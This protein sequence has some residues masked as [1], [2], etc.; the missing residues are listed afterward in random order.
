M[1]TM[2]LS[3]PSSYGLWDGEKLLAECAF[4]KEGDA[5]LIERITVFEPVEGMDIYDALLRAVTSF[6]S[7]FAPKTV[8]CREQS[9]FEELIRLRFVAKDGWV[10]STPEEVLRHLCCGDGQ[11]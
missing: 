3:S 10:E 6:M 2:K 7:R 5:L 4:A 1:I 9:L 8:L 11:A